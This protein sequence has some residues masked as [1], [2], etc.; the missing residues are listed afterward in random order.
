MSPTP[1]KPEPGRAGLTELLARALTDSQFREK[2]FSD[3]E[4]AVQEYQLSQGDLEAVAHLDRKEIDQQAQSLAHGASSRAGVRLVQ[5]I[6][7]D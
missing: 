7:V 2:L 5:R 3:R 4:A 6:H 1:N